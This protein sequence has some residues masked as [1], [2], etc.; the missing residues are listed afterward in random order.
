MVSMNKARLLERE[1]EEKRE[2]EI[3]MKRT[4]KGEPI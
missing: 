3:K 4:K 2:S 1:K